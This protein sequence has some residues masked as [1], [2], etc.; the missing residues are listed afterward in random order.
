MIEWATFL[1]KTW[2]A[3]TRYLLPHMVVRRR[4]VTHQI[5]LRFEKEF[6]GSSWG[7]RLRGSTLLVAEEEALRMKEDLREKDA[8][9]L[10]AWVMQL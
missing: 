4:L 3:E 9:R 7:N 8:W 1:A 10:A 5:D 6:V 2:Y